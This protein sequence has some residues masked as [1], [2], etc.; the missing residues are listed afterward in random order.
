MKT[1]ILHKPRNNI[2]TKYMDKYM[3]KY[4]YM[5]SNSFCG[6]QCEQNVNIIPC[7]TFTVLTTNKV[8]ANNGEN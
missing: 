7:G 6:Q 8:T 4:M 1:Y 2:H 5:D 3:D